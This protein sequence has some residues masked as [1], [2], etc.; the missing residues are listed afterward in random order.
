MNLKWRIRKDLALLADISPSR[1]TEEIFK[2]IHSPHAKE[3][4]ESL[5]ALGIYRFLQPEAAEL[6]KTSGGFRAR[7][8]KT[9]EALSKEGEGRSGAILSA[10]VRDYLEDAADWNGERPAAER[11]RNAFILARKFVLPM[12]PPRSELDDA[13]RLLFAEHGTVI[14]KTRFNE[15][16]RR[17]E[18]KHETA[19]TGDKHD[20]SSRAAKS[21]AESPFPETAPGRRRRR[22]GKAEGPAV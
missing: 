16:G 5:D 4:I 1:L 14:K 20:G 11:C 9:F 18:K 13:I 2:I 12:N 8:L 15:R 17:S 3:I 6:F 21:P 22:P 10:L 19:K 7:Y